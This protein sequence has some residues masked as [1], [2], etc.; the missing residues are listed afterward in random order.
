[1]RYESCVIT[2][3]GRRKNNEDNFYCN[4]YYK[5]ET[6]LNNDVYTDRSYSSNNLYSVCDGMGGEEYG[7]KASLI[8][9]SALDKYKRKDMR[10]NI[11]AYVSEA[12]Q[13]ICELIRSNG[14]IRSGS[15]VA[16]LGIDRG[17]A[18]A[19]NIGDSRVY[20][21][22][23]GE[24][25]QLSQDHTK[26]EQLCRMGAITK[27]EARSHKD[28]HIITQHLGLF[29]DEIEL[30]PYISEETA[31]EPGDKFLL[32]SDG[33]TDMLDD[34]SISSILGE[35]ISC[36]AAVEALVDTALKNGGKDN[37]TAQLIVCNE[38]DK[39]SRILQRIVVGILIVSA[40]AA[41]SFAAYLAYT[42]I[43]GG[44]RGD[45]TAP[46]EAPTE[47][48]AP[49]RHEAAKTGMEVVGWI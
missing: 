35:D 33:L 48:F 31:I 16:I 30:S 14:G 11:K 39:K 10:S 49:A 45:R 12:N 29:P 34:A 41:C 18:T 8:A 26:V 44:D 1:M 25:T 17:K 37:I 42:F 28:R 22:R 2:D 21:L 40:V 23:N 47:I 3:V 20:L 7:E 9:V 32:C 27:E 19:Y 5:A 4:G 36:K 6:S 38:I 13:G 46:E 24:L 15:T 43:N